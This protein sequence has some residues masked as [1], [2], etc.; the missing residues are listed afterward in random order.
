MNLRQAIRDYRKNL[1]NDRPMQSHDF[2]VVHFYDRLVKRK[3][4]K[5]IHHFGGDDE[6]F[7]DWQESTFFHATG[8]FYLSRD[9]I[10]MQPLGKLLRGEA[11]YINYWT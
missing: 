1:T 5:I 4:E 9:A 11:I 7:W 2:K 8:H 10:V 3:I 6:C